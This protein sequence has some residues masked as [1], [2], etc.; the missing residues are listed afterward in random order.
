MEAFEHVVKSYMESQDYIVSTNV[1]FP[2]KMRTRKSAYEEFQ[3]HGYEV[4]IV[5]ARA[6]S[7]VLGSVKSFLG[8]HGVN[9]RGFRRLSANSGDREYD[10]YRIFNDPEV[11]NGI[12]NGASAQY[13]YPRQSIEI[14]LFVGKFKSEQEQREIE[15]HVG[16]MEDCGVRFEVVG[17]DKILHGLMEKAK[18]RTYVNDPV[19]MTLKALDAAGKLFNG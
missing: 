12:I 2:V 15:K 11:R 14:K 9:R 4:D 1:K 13:G 7:L 18:E 5:A 19:I 3:T 17:L 16:A 6:E 8:S 10:Q